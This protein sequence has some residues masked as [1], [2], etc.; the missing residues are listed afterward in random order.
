M[1]LI[2]KEEAEYLRRKFPH[3]NIVRTMKQHSDRHRYYVEESMKVMN[4]L[5][6]FERSKTYEGWW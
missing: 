4:A 2:G 5:R 6:N 1:V 3:L